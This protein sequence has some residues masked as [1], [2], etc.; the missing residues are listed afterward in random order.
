MYILNIKLLTKPIEAF[1]HYFN[2]SFIHSFVTK[3]LYRKFLDEVEQEFPKVSKYSIWKQTRQ[4]R[5]S[6]VYFWNL[7]Q[8]HALNTISFNNYIHKKY[9]IFFFF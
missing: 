3:R 8:T 4:Q 9:Q 5:I 6:T 1:S 7:L 2:N